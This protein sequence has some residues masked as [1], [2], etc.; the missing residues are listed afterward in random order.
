MRDEGE[1]FEMRSV[2]DEEFISVPEAAK[3]MRLHPSRLKRLIRVGE[4]ATQRIGRRRLAVRRADLRALAGRLRARPTNHWSRGISD[5]IPRT[6]LT[7][8]ERQRALGAL[9]RAHRNATALLGQPG[10]YRGPQSWELLAEA[11]QE[12]DEQQR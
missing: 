12:R 5:E 9:E 8:G 6:R 2:F 4:L 3:L 7:P 11:R 1:Q 10:S